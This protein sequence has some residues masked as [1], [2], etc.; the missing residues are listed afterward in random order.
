MGY[1]GVVIL[2]GITKHG[3]SDIHYMMWDHSRNIMGKG[4][5]ALEIFDYLF[6][7]RQVHHVVGMI[8]AHNQAA[9]RFALSVGM[10]YEGEIRENVLYK[11]TYYN[12]SIYGI[13]E[14]EYLGRRARLL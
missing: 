12:T 8:P 4:G 6:F 14:R 10:K 7:K 2:S 9:V 13:L 5:P 11:G 3:S 1:A